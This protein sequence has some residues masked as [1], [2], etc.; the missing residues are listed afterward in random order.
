MRK[1]RD[2]DFFLELDGIGQ[3]RFGRR[4]Y[5]DRCHIRAKYLELTHGVTN[6]DQLST[7]A[8]MIAAYSILCVEC[9]KGWEDI[10]NTSIRDFEDNKL[11]DL[12]AAWGPKEDS[13]R[14]GGETEGKSSGGVDG[15]LVPEEVSVTAA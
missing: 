12:F 4:T 7:Y 5:G 13:F 15:V 9:P 8:S 11:F 6:D 3:F 14:K 2:T 1:P 10:E